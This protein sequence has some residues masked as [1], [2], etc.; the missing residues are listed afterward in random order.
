MSALLIVIIYLCLLLGLGYLSSKHFRGTSRDFFVASHSIGPFLLLM[1]LFG[2]TMTAFALVGST[3]K[4]FE[5]GVG[6][7]GLMAS[8]SALV[9]S[10]I[11]FF[12]G[13]RLWAIGKKNGFITQVQFFRARFNSNAIG[14]VLFPILVLLVIPYVLIGILGAGKTLLPVTA[15]AF[16]SLF[17]NPSTPHWAG[18]VPS[19][20]TGL[21]ICVVVL[22]YVFMGG[23]RGTAWANA[24]QTLIFMIMGLVA[25]VFISKTLGG[26][27]KAALLSAQFDDH[28][29]LIQ[30]HYFDEESRSMQLNNPP[31][32]IGHYTGNPAE[33]AG[34]HP[35]LSRTPTSV[36][37][38]KNVD[39]EMITF[40][41]EFGFGKWL[42][43][44][45]LFIPLSAG[46]F[47]HLFQHW[48]SAKGA[49]TF[50][51][52]I[53]A[54]PL[55]ILIVWLPCV[56]IGS[57]ATGILEPLKSNEVGSVLGS[58]LGLLVGSPLL[59][60]L[61]TAGILAAIMSSLDSQFLCLGTIFTN[62]IVL[63]TLGRDRFSEKQII[64]LARCF[65]VAVVT[66]S[67]LLSLVAPGNIFDLAIWC[68]TGFASL[69][70]L[71]IASLYWRRT[72]LPG[73]FASI[74]V[75]VICWLK[76]FVES[77]F[78]GEY[79]IGPGIIPA[80]F[81]VLSSTA[82]LVIVSLST[83]PPDDQTL[84]RFFSKSSKSKSS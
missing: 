48:L 29:K 65:V 31:K 18:G 4:S 70:P 49:H 38:Y 41:H 77:G 75:A 5:R 36:I 7:F 80:A 78:G 74:A 6:V 73:A 72:S 63:H 56:L 71:L 47:P 83:R 19:W 20:L 23:S 10:A 39:G 21:V 30:T 13:T 42:F 50:R 35:L 62:D 66:L 54:H 12:I 82:A 2:T 52:T 33:V 68:F 1:S 25:F 16:P 58:M 69:V 26:L 27:K 79:A 57:W 59:S 40:E 11:F 32:I 22:S 64:I 17:P 8:V 61:L 46:M 55:C 9:H 53:I 45:Y 34:R 15:G 24:F 60:G 51:L 67:Y 84:S 76:S 81:C 28:G 37:L 43:F 44:T 14:Y 3:G